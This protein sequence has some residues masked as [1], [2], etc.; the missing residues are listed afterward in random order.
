MDPNKPPSSF[1][2]A[3][4]GEH[5][6][7][8]HCLCDM[9]PGYEALERSMMKDM[10][11]VGRARARLDFLEKFSVEGRVY[12]DEGAARA[13]ADEW[14]ASSGL[15]AQLLRDDLLREDGGWRVV[16]WVAADELRRQIKRDG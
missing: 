7:D 13:A 6:D 10:Q 9:A 15:R 12:P 1:E 16:P 14:T 4:W 3:M 5:V 2:E 11:I 8:S